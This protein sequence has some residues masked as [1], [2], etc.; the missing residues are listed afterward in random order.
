MAI[1][2]ISSEFQ[3]DEPTPPMKPSPIDGLAYADVK[4]LFSSINKFI[5]TQD[6]AVVINRPD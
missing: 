3:N 4:E 2:F 5:K 6:Y 1:S